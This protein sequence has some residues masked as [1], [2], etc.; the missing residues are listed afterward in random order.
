MSNKAYKNM[1]RIFKAYINE[2]IVEMIDKWHGA[3]IQHSE[4]HRHCGIIQHFTESIHR[5]LKA[6][7]TF[8]N[9]MLQVHKTIQ[10]ECKPNKLPV[11]TVNYLC[12]TFSH[13]LMSVSHA[14]CSLD[15]FHW[16]PS[17]STSSVT[18]I[19]NQHQHFSASIKDLVGWCN[20]TV[21]TILII[22]QDYD[23]I[24]D[25]SGNSI[26]AENDCYPFRKKWPVFQ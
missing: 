3:Q 23:Y 26:Y 15:S 17:S 24:F 19:H 4:E 1:Q 9:V 20:S 22:L 11:S 6:E 12:T 5:L 13:V 25:K 14:Q 8:T 21:N 16:L 7:A 2:H 18:T 10:C